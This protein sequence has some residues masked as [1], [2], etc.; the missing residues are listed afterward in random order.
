MNASNDSSE[1]E[2][3]TISLPIRTIEVFNTA[4]YGQITSQINA[5]PA[6]TA[7]QRVFEFSLRLA[8]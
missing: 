1:F 4:N 8:S 5:G 7:P 6:G 3:C 2:E